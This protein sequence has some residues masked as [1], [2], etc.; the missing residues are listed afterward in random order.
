MR[1]RVICKQELFSTPDIESNADI[2]LAK[3]HLILPVD[4]GSTAIATTTNLTSQQVA[5]HSDWTNDE[6]DEIK[7]IFEE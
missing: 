5:A 6:E 7:R 1:P 4:N 3:S 2:M